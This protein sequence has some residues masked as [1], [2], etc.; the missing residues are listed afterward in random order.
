MSSSVFIAQSREGINATTLPSYF[1]PAR[2]FTDIGSLLDVIVPALVMVATL[3]LLAMLIYA[4]FIY[5]TSQ[6]DPDKVV[7]ARNIATY[8]ILGLVL[9]MISFLIVRI[10]EYVFQLNLPI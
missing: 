6:G 3:G 4:S 9:I 5:L 7:E 10:I 8:A 1:P 2:Y